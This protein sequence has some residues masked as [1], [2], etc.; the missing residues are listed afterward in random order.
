MK[1]L[2]NIPVASIMLAI[3]ILFL[4]SPIVLYWWINADY[5]RYLWIINGPEPFSN[6]GSGPYQLVL[7]G[8]L[9]LVGIMFI[10]VAR[11]LRRRA[12]YY[13]E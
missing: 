8:A 1:G 11:V 6:F 5:E 9:I 10:V 2:S 12:L 13:K 3:G 4:L 7:Y